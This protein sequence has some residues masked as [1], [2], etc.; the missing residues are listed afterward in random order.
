MIKQW[1]TV[2]DPCQN[3]GDKLKAPT[4]TSIIKIAIL[5]LVIAA[6]IFIRPLNE[7]I[8]RMAD[9]FKN[10]DSVKAYIRSFGIWAVAISFLMMILQSLAAPIP[11]FF[12]TFANAAIWGWGKGAILSWTSAMAG[13]AICFAVSRIYGRGV[14]ERFASKMALENV[15]SFFEK[16]GKNAILVARLLP[17][18]PFDP[19][20]YAAGLTPMKFGGFFLATGLGQLPAT[21]IYSYAAAKSA[22]PGTWVNGLLL[23]FG[24]AIAGFTVKKIWT[25]RQKAAIKKAR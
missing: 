21:L 15:E 10:V 13:A 3:E 14:V 20:S 8:R 2:T 12:I 6:F 18:V 19:V 25:D 11:A 22:D 1:G 17:F 4:K 9:A 24:I 5:L 16:Y 7:G 23:L